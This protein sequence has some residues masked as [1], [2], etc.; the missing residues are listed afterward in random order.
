MTES[1][2]AIRTSESD[3]PSLVALL[4][5]L[6]Y[7]QV[8]LLLRY[9]V[10]TASQFVG[11]AALFGIVF[12]GGK[13]VAGAALT[14]SLDGIIVGFFL[15]SL[16][17]VAYSG[18][19]WNVT[20]EAQWGTLERLY[21]SPHGFRTVM[22]VKAVVN[23]CMSFLWGAALLVLMM[24]ASGRWLS[25]DPVTVLPLT[26]MTLGS[27][28]GIGFVF[29]G[30]ALVYKRVENAFQLV[31]FGLIGLIAAPAGNVEWMKLFPV[32]HGS[33]L[34]GVAMEQGVRLWEF[35]LADLGLLVLTTS[36]YL[37]LGFYVFHRAIGRARDEGLLGH[38]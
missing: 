27:V 15:Y 19:S 2:A 18:L 36:F 32:S 38:Y 16:S 29:A 24:A 6:T 34:T 5:V 17:M 4:K 13:A 37:A 31:Q 30:L 23:V 9:P 7:K 1:G 28:L 11:L 22:T 20:R 10:N 25:I 33:Y 21:V 14:D 3:G 8:I 26:A 12:F 35:P